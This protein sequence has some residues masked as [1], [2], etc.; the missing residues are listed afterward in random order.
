MSGLDGNPE[1]R[2]SR[3]EAQ[4]HYL[5]LMTST[6]PKF[7]HA[8]KLYCNLPKLQTRRP[9]LRVLHQNNANGLANSEDPDQQQSDLGLHCLTRPICPKDFGS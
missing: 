2:F 6:V 5:D 7:L 9:I 1:D 8:R 3:N 4:L